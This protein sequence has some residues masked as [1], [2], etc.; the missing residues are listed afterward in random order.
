[1]A[2]LSTVAAAIA[3][4]PVNFGVYPSGYVERGRDIFAVQVMSEG[5]TVFVHA[6]SL[7][8]LGVRAAEHPKAVEWTFTN[9][10]PIP[11]RVAGNE[12]PPRRL[13]K[14]ESAF[15]WLPVWYDEPVNVAGLEVLVAYS[16]DGRG[17][18]INRHIYWEDEEWTLGPE[19]SVTG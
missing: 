7:V 19:P 9:S 14:G 18:A 12:T 2:S 16:L 6:A 15:F 10:S 4:V 5:A 13:H 3:S 8:N 17:P 11:L 1:M